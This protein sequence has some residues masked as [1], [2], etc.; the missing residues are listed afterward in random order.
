MATPPAPVVVQTAA[1]GGG[2]VVSSRSG[3]SAP[4][5]L[6]TAP[7]LQ[8]VRVSSGGSAAGASADKAA[9]VRISSPIALKVYERARP[10]GSVPGADV[11]LAPGHHDVE[12]ANPALGYRLQQSLDV[13]AGEIVSIHVAPPQ[14]FVSV[15]ST[16]PAEV[17]IDGQ[18]MG[19]T[20]LGPLPLALGDHDI[21]FRHPAG[22]KDHQRVTVKSGETARVIGNI[23]R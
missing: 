1:T 21:T 17:T 16:P 15:Y 3:E 10:L 11:R 7:D 5:R 13:R 4:L 14:G 23:R 19:R 2:V 18:P 22:I 8:W 6:T 20:P 9:T 12:L